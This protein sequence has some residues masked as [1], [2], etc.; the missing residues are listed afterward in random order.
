MGLFSSFDRRTNEAMK[1]P[2]VIIVILNWNGADLLIDCLDSVREIDYPNYE[3][4]VVDNGSTDNS[5]VVIQKNYPDVKIL[6]LPENR[7]Y[8]R[9]NNAGFTHAKD[10]GDFIVVLN[11]DTT[12]D[13][14]LLNELIKPFKDNSSII[15]T[16]PKIYYAD[17]PDLIWYAGGYVN[18]WLGIINHVGIR[19]KDEKKYLVEINTDYAT[20]CCFCMRMRDYEKFKGFNETFEMYGEDVNLSLMIRNTGGKVRMIPTAK[21]W[22]KVSASSGGSGSI[23]RLLKRLRSNFRI[24]YARATIFQWITFVI[25]LPVLLIY[26]IYRFFIV[27]YSSYQSLSE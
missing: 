18:L 26:Y 11:N 7:G 20:G 23:S 19:K 2:T 8:A 17:Q 22:H 6:Q 16:A 21:I 13:K 4:L 15:Q 14:Q 24:M 25:S 1:A 3:I 27:K 5:V 9:G 12:V 10:W